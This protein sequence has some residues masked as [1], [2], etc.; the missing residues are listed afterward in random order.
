LASFATLCCV[1][2]SPLG[3]KAQ[4]VPVVFEPQPRRV[5]AGRDPQIAVRA[6]GELFLTKTQGGNL[7]L[8]TSHDGGDSFDQGV[9]VNDVEGE[10]ASHAEASP[11]MTVR[12]MREF[13]VAWQADAGGVNKLRL[14]RS[15]DWGETFSKAIE[16]DPASTASQSFFTMAVSPKGVIYAAWLDGRDRAKTGGS[17]VYLARSTDRGATFEKSVRVSLDTSAEVCPC[18]RPSIAFGAGDTLHV[19]WRAVFSNNVRDFVVATSHDG[20]QSWQPATLV[21]EDNWSINGCP[22][23]GSSMAMFGKRLYVSWYTVREKHSEIYIAYSDDDGRT[24]SGRQSLSENLLDPNH[25]AL[26]E[27]GGKVVALFQARD[28]QENSGWGKIA[29]YYREVD[30]ASRL[31]PLVR[32]GQLA[33]SASYP[34][35]VWEDPGRL[36][37]VWTESSPDGPGIVLARG[38]QTPGPVSQAAEVR[39]NRRER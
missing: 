6:S 31:S 29:A 11:L 38:R 9:R 12:T 21:A 39:E 33:G 27:V 5:V 18:C 24:F 13:Y 34:T 2:L 32:V 25:P 15:I 20:G 16:I 28:P 35:L 8:H 10:V 30:A 23:S 22:H 26:F 7:W 3:L 37:V 17:A 1:S 4:E 36:F 14:A 19:S